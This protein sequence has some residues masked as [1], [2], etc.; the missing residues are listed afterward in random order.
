[1]QAAPEVQVE[2]SVDHLGDKWAIDTIYGVKLLRAISAQL[3][4]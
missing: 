1:M 2:S 3:Y 4:T